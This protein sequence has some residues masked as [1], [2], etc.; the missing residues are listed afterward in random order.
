MN[1]DRLK[2]RISPCKNFGKED[3]SRPIGNVNPKRFCHLTGIQISDHE[4]TKDEVADKY[5][6]YLVQE[7]SVATSLTPSVKCDTAVDANLLTCISPFESDGN[8]WHLD[9]FN[10]SL[11]LPRTGELDETNASMNGIRQLSRRDLDSGVFELPVVPLVTEHLQTYNKCALD[12]F[13]QICKKDISCC[14]EQQHKNRCIDEVRQY[15]L[16]VASCVIVFV[17]SSHRISCTVA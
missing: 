7:N 13:C 15:C 5:E 6:S 11:R 14:D 17:Y 2:R 12:E 10:S 8:L 1:R 4:I 16:C 9:D 3:D